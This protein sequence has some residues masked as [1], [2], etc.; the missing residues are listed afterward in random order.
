[1]SK[2]FL[3]VCVTL[4][5]ST[6]QFEN[7][8]LQA[9]EWTPESISLNGPMVG[10]TLGYFFMGDFQGG[11]NGEFDVMIAD[12]AIT[13]ADGTVT[14][15]PIPLGSFSWGGDTTAV[16]NGSFVGEQVSATSGQVG[17]IFPARYYLADHLGTAQME[18][19]RGGWPVW[20]GE[21]SP[22]G[23]E[24]DDDSSSYATFR[25]LDP[26]HGRFNRPDPYVGSYDLSNPQSLNRYS[27]VL[28]N[29]LR[30]VDQLGLNEGDY[31][32]DQFGN[33]WY[34]GADGTL[35]E[36][37]TTVNVNGNDCGTDCISYG[38]SGISS[39]VN[40]VASSDYSGS[41]AAPNNTTKPTTCYRPGLVGRMAAKALSWLSGDGGG[42]LLGIS[43]GVA[44]GAVAADGT[45]AF[46]S[47]THGNVGMMTT[48]A[49]SGGSV[50]GAS[51]SGGLSFGASNYS[52]LSG[53]AS[54]ST[55]AAI[56]GGDGLGG[57]ASLSVNSSGALYTLTA[58]G[59]YGLS[60]SGGAS[61][62]WVTPLCK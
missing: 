14:Q 20:K 3:Y 11:P 45:R 47:D 34:E 2:G 35:S 16:S 25:N 1:M 36:L 38:P 4:T 22:F 26:V 62:S 8:I 55:Q 41:G 9:D 12:L 32:Q 31:W 44:G 5:A 51:A 6:E 19:A 28:N 21:F 29:P 61:Y 15:F 18:F 46:V 10:K 59:G 57:S 39:T 27:Y 42:Y 17:A 58:G 37:D 24:T 48:I 52:S 33:L 50:L 30:Y 54:W 13:H 60:V 43:G 49:L 56:S 53:Y 7:T 40:T 23:Q